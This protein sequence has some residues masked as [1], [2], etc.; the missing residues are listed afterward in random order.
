MYGQ[1]KDMSNG[2]DDGADALFAGRT[3][4]DRARCRG[5]RMR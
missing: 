5:V 2:C 3:F 4:H 1:R